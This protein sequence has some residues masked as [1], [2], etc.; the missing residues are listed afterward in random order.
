MEF[1]LQQHL[2]A[3]RFTDQPLPPP[4]SPKTAEA[5]W[6]AFLKGLRSQGQGDKSKEPKPESAKPKEG[7]P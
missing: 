3:L 5:L 1:R 7:K 2:V 4:P 6:N